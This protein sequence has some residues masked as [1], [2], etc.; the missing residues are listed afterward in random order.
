MKPGRDSAVLGG[1]QPP[2]Y[3]GA[4][5]GGWEG[6]VLRQPVPNPDWLR[7]RKGFLT[8]LKLA[9]GWPTP[10]LRKGPDWGYRAAR[11]LGD[12]PQLWVI[13]YYNES[14]SRDRRFIL[15]WLGWIKAQPNQELI[16][17]WWAKG[18]R[19][20]RIWRQTPKRL[21]WVAVGNLS[22][23]WDSRKLPVEPPLRGN[24][25]YNLMGY[26]LG[27]ALANPTD[28]SLQVAAIRQPGGSFPTW[29]NPS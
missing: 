11:V 19:E 29:A 18:E 10:G 17:D 21:K 24:E 27:L 8:L 6:N 15:E 1:N 25:A 14:E 26:H 4:V 3:S 28:I 5:L 7:W 16:P 9:Q 2:P 20:F 12:I 13:A 23:G 22:P